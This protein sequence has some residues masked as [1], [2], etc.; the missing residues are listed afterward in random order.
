[1]DLWSSPFH[2]FPS[3][4]VL[5]VVGDKELLVFGAVTYFNLKKT[6][7]IRRLENLSSI[8]LFYFANHLWFGCRCTS[9]QQRNLCHLHAWCSNSFKKNLTQDLLTVLFWRSSQSQWLQWKSYWCYTYN[10]YLKTLSLESYFSLLTNAWIAFTNRNY[11]LTSCSSL[12]K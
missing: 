11:V 4:P 3:V 5:L 6:E 10:F 2:R 8:H 1:M 9:R 7:L 12:I